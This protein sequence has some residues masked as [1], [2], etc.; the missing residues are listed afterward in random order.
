MLEDMARK[1]ISE[2]VALQ[3]ERPDCQSIIPTVL[4]LKKH[5][6]RQYRFR[7]LKPG[8]SITYV[9]SIVSEIQLE[10]DMLE[11]ALLADNVPKALEHAKAA[12][13]ALG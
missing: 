5:I 9:N 10:L 6:G 13:R 3:G 2:I 4:N 12:L 11:S 7:Q 1:I 8:D